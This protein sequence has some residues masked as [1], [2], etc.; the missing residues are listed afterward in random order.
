[1]KLIQAN[2]FK[3]PLMDKSVH[4][5]VTSPPYYSLRKYSGE[6]Q[7][8][9]GDKMC[10]HEWGSELTTKT[11]DNYNKGFNERY[12][13]S[14][15]Q[16][17]QEAMNYGEL[18]NG[19]FC[20]KC[21]AWRGAYGLEPT[22]QMYIDHTVEWAR[23]VWR[24][25][26]DDGTFWLNLGDSYAGSGGPGNQRDNKSAKGQFEKFTNPNRDTESHGL[27]P[28]DLMGIP[29]RVALALQA[30]GWY[31]RRDNIWAK[32]SWMPESVK[33]WRWEQH[34]VKI[35]KGKSRT[36]KYQTFQN[37]SGNNIK[38]KAKY[39]DCPGCSKCNPNNGLI[40]KKGAG[41]STSSHEYIFLFSKN[42]TYYYDDIAV[43]E[44]AA[45]DGRKDTVMK[46]SEKY[47]DGFVPNQ[48]EQ[49]VAKRGHERWPSQNEQGQKTRNRRSVWSDISP[50]NYKGKHY[51]AFPSDLPE[52]CIKAGTSEKGVC[53]ECGAGWARVVERTIGE[54]KL[55]PKTTASHHARGGEGIP[56]G[57]VGKAGSSRI[58]AT[59]TTTGW[60]AT[61]E[62]VQLRSNLTTKE[63][64]YVESELA[65]HH[66][67]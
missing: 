51:A 66:S 31:L 56:T 64:E 24:V 2:A 47:A 14:S 40:L 15:G 53:P 28:K 65:K 41:R 34:K 25:L 4:C 29:W 17:K 46:G 63:K 13:H 49:T 19:N 38:G 52:I 21:N 7:F 43:Q 42:D 35:A 45:Y 33:G 11:S 36:Q 9:F 23:E 37:H 20:H 67:Q 12:G 39:K 10:E 30:D 22:L 27:K 57:T 58:D 60:R 16:K 44:I 59:S 8:V 48:P 26:R 32:K 5:A 6:Q 50:S 18:S 3:I 61:C 1:M 55:T 54:A 62:H